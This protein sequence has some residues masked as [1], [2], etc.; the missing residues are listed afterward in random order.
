MEVVHPTAAVHDDNYSPQ[1]PEPSGP[2]S[3]STRPM[4]LSTIEGWETPH[5]TSDD[6]KFYSDEEPKKIYLLPSSPSPPPPLRKLTRK[7]SS[8][9]SF[10]KRTV[11]SRP[12]CKACGQTLFI[13]K[14]I[15]GSSR[16]WNRLYNYI[17]VCFIY[18]L[19]V[20]N[21]SDTEQLRITY[22]IQTAYHWYVS[23]K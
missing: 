22:F 10:P 2:S 16:D 4:N 3:I 23:S 13:R 19:N 15:G 21:I 7:M 9:M 6:S 14:N 1:S 8:G 17:T 12:A 5:T 11:V 18:K 20:F